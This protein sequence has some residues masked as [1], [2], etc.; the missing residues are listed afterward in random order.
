MLP[1]AQRGDGRDRAA[2]LARERDQVL[3]IVVVVTDVPD[4]RHQM[5]ALAGEPF[6][7]SA[8]GAV[9]P[10]MEMNVGD[11]GDGEAVELGRQAGDGDVMPRD[12]DGGW[13]DEEPVAQRGGAERADA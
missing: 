8:G 6:D 11:A 12:L 1:V 4:Q 7:G 13:L 10:V 2:G 5:R 3:E 9:D